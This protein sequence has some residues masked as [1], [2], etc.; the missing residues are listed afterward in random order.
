VQEMKPKMAL[1]N[2]WINKRPNLMKDDIVVILDERESKVGPA[3]RYPLARVLDTIKGHDVLVRKVSLLKYPA[4]PGNAP[5]IRG[6]NSVYVILPASDQHEEKEKEP[7]AN[8]LPDQ[9]QRKRKRVLRFFS[10]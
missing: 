10:V 6:I 3:S 4:R 2:K 1:Y 7:E 9:R 5:T 8:E